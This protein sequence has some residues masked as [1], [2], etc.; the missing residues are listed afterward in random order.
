MF[1]FI[2][3][4][5]LWVHILISLVLVFLVLFLFLNYLDVLTKHGKILT[6]PSVN[7]KDLAEATKL[8]EERGFDVEIQ[9]SVFVDTARANSV[10]RQFPDADAVVKVNR[11]VY[12]TINRSVP[13][14]IDMPNFMSMTFRSAEV[15]LKQYGLQLEDTIYRHDFA[16]NAVLDQLYNGNSIK[17]GSKISMGSKI[18]LVLG[19]GLGQDEFAV[20]DLVGLT[21]EQ[22]RALLEGNGLAIGASIFDRD[23]VDS[24]N[25]YV[26]LQRPEKMTADNRVIRIRQGQSIDVFLGVKKPER[27]VD[28][29]GVMY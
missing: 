21:Y 4:K 22:A 18:T 10:V 26:Y 12:L 13:P 14:V 9:D 15:A 20:P 8:L 23:V 16:K 2:S 5:P 3:S 28:S 27:P 1:K 17:P 19:S 6:I 25:S 7:G 29:S 24:A 11:T